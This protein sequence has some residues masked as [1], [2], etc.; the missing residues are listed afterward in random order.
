MGIKSKPNCIVGFQMIAAK[1]TAETAPDAP[2][3]L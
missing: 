1:I 2:N 3:A